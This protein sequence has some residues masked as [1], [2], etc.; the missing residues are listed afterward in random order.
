MCR[1]TVNAFLDGL[2]RMNPDENPP[3]PYY[4]LR[5]TAEGACFLTNGDGD[6]E[7]FDACGRR[8]GRQFPPTAGTFMNDW[9]WSGNCAPADALVHARPVPSP[10]PSPRPSPG[11]TPPTTTYDPCP[12]PIDVK[13]GFNP[14]PPKRTP[15]WRNLGSITPL[16]RGACRH[17][18]D[19][20]PDAVCAVDEGC[21]DHVGSV[22]ERTY[23]QPEAYQNGNGF[24]RDPVE[25]TTDGCVVTVGGV[26]HVPCGYN[27]AF[28]T[29]S[30]NL[31]ADGIFLQNGPMDVC[32]SMPNLDHWRC[33][34][35]RMSTDG[36][37][38]GFSTNDS[39]YDKPKE[40]RAAQAS[41]PPLP[42]RLGPVA[43]FF[44][45]IGK[46]LSWIWPF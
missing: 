41:P 22:Y 5:C 3:T 16:V 25:R 34:S 15:G 9:E 27:L 6:R 46:A 2:N 4:R 13:L 32:V 33:Q 45:S 28:A 23:G 20:S 21:A 43:R 24:T 7:F 30:P 31:W 35:G 37:M 42:P 10:T 36:K 17:K 1:S 14:N 38:E 18:G 26:D 44:R 39:G 12:P 19:A 40:A 11:P 29:S 8:Y